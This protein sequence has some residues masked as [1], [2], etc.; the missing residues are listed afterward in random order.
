MGASV[1]QPAVISADP[2]RN[3]GLSRG[4]RFF[5]KLEWVLLHL[6]GPAQLG[7][8][9]DP[10]VQ[11]EHARRALQAKARAKRL[12]VSEAE[13]RSSIPLYSQARAARKQKRSGPGARA[14]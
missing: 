10:R 11:K 3:E 7:D 5:W 4:Y 13:A 12:G 9:Q 6:Y 1:E 2:Y 14:D 8:A